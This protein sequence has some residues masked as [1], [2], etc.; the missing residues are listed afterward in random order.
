MPA[1]FLACISSGGRVRTK[2]LS[3]NRYLPICFDKAGKS[4]PG[5]PKAGKPK[6]KAKA[7]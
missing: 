3:G 1:D 6:V 4:F 5:E 2:K 7:K